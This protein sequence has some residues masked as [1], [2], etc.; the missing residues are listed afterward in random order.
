MKSEDKVKNI[1]IKGC[2]SLNKHDYTNEKALMETTLFLQNNLNF[3]N[4]LS[5]VEFIDIKTSINELKN[6][7]YVCFELV[8][9]DI[10]TDYIKSKYKVRQIQEPLEL[11]L[12]VD[13][14]IILE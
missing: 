13:I 10:N 1:L 6:E 8:S 12:G 14:S 9:I 2:Y 3:I 4:R 5:E 7:I 11:L